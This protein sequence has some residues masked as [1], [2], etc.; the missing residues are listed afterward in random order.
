MKTKTEEFSKLIIALNLGMM[1]IMQTI[2]IT[3]ETKTIKFFSDSFGLSL[4]IGL[5]KVPKMS[6][7]PEIIALKFLLSGIH[8]SN[9][10][11][12]KLT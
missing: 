10:I 11:F 6:K 9:H 5:T 3:Y 1:N 8:P 7:I 12:S 4:L 2:D